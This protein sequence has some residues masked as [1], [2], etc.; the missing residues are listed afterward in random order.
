[1]DPIRLHI[2]QVNSM[3]SLTV[4][5]VWWGWKMAILYIKRLPFCRWV[6]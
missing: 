4:V 1:M 2:P 3:M 6:E 5:C